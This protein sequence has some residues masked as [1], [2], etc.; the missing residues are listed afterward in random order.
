MNYSGGTLKVAENEKEGLNALIARPKVNRIAEETLKATSEIKNS[1]ESRD[2]AITFKSEL[3]ILN[4]A[5][6][7]VESTGDRL[8]NLILGLSELISKPVFLIQLPVILG[9]VVYF[10]LKEGR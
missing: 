3:K 1:T 2:N 9:I 7:K 6:Y 4:L 8:T 5:S 10:L